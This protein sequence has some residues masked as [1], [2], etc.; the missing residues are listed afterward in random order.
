MDEPLFY[1]VDNDLISIFDIKIRLHQSKY[2][3]R[4]KSFDNTSAAFKMLASDYRHIDDVPDIILINF[5]LDG[6]DGLSFLRNLEKNGLLSDKTQVYILSIYGGPEH[7]KKLDE[8][9]HV[10]GWITK[11]L[12]NQHI[13]K[14]FSNYLNK[15]NQ[16]QLQAM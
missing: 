8:Y 7:I 16:N 15:G 4:S 10:I 12:S 3:L 14:I 6:I 2:K 11:P 13:D 5:D 1:I 9:R